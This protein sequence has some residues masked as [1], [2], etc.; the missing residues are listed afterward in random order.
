MAD[1]LAFEVLEA[2]R[3][4]AVLCV[5]RRARRAFEKVVALCVELV[6]EADLLLR[7]RFLDLR[8]L[9]G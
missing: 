5:E 7:V 3:D 6:G 4:V 2:R 8:R 9:I 1:E